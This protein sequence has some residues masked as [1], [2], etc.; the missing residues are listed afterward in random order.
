MKDSSLAVLL[1]AKVAVWDQEPPVRS[2]VFSGHG[3]EHVGGWLDWVRLEAFSN[4][5]PAKTPIKL[6][7]GTD[8]SPY[9]ACPK[10]AKRKEKFSHTA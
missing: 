2:N 1:E 10:S 4:R 7:A 6:G 8:E 3:A 9:A 5:A